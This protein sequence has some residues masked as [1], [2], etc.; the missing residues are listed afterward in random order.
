MVSRPIGIRKNKTN[1]L[2]LIASVFFIT[3]CSNGESEADNRVENRPPDINILSPSPQIQANEHDLIDFRARADDYEDGDLSSQIEWTSDLQGVLD[4]GAS[5]AMEL[6]AGTHL[7]TASVT[8]SANASVEQALRVEVAE[9]NSNAAVFWSA[10]T[11]NVDNTPLTD[12]IGFKVYYGND[13]EQ[14]TRFVE[15]NDPTR[16]SVVIENLTNNQRYYFAVTAV[17]SLGV[18]SDFAP[19]VSKD[20]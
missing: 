11:E 6:D 15:V 3:S 4:D 5:F 8:D 1:G 12:L 19:L 16:L 20:T 2:L 17:N 14:L 18:E 7:I 13:P 10:P 9:A